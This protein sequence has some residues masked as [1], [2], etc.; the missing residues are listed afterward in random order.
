MKTTPKKRTPAHA[1]HIDKP[2]KKRSR[3]PK[4][5]PPPPI[6]TR[7]ALAD[8]VLNTSDDALAETCHVQDIGKPIGAVLFKRLTVAGG[9][10]PAS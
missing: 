5:P 8:A 3:T 1:G 2:K 10:R 4:K 7:T 9:S 6:P